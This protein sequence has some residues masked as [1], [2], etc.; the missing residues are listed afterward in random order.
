MQSI[1][2]PNQNLGIE[3]IWCILKQFI[4]FCVCIK[5]VENSFSKTRAFIVVIET[6]KDQFT[7]TKQAWAARG[8]WATWP[9]LQP[10]QSFSN[11]RLHWCICRQTP[12]SGSGL[13]VSSCSHRTSSTAFKSALTG[14]NLGSSCSNMS[15][16][17]LNSLWATPTPLWKLVCSSRSAGF[18]E[19][20][21]KGSMG[22]PLSNLAVGSYWSSASGLP[23]IPL[24]YLRNLLPN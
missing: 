12:S 5:N 15:S 20:L 19:L 10:D 8:T 6:L 16:G 4:S 11:V 1:W 9:D 3:N 2:I 14:T 24:S 17:T 18:E 13:A 22:F 7:W 23:G 21:Q